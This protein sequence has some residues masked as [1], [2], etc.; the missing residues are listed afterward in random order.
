MQHLL[1]AMALFGGIASDTV[2][3]QEVKKDVQ[4]YKRLQERGYIQNKEEFAKHASEI[5]SKN[6]SEEEIEELAKVDPTLWA[7]VSGFLTFVNIVLFIAACLLVL[8]VAWLIGGYLID[9]FTEIPLAAYE[10]FGYLIAVTGVLTAVNWPAYQIHIAFPCSL[11]L[12]PTVA[13]THKRLDLKGFNCFEFLICSFAWGFAA[14]YVNSAVLGFLSV[15]AFFGFLGFS[16]FVMPFC[17]IIGFNDDASIARGTTSAFFI[18]L[19]HQFVTIGNHDGEV[20][21]LFADGMSI[22]GPF[23]Y[24]I[25]L[26]IVANKW[27]CRDGFQCLVLNIVTIISGLVA[28]YVGATYGD[29]RLLG[30]SGTLFAIWLIEKY[31]EIPW[32]GMGWAWSVLGLSG[33]LYGIAI[34]SQNHPEYFMW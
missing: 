29:S 4:A 11:A 22:M 12:I 18:T 3:I 2:N 33:I 19:I 9:F 31:Y 14:I 26:L 25:G 21:K 5:I 30:I 10:F 17:A 23:V 24:F 28:M 34:Y 16:V 1:L 13:L 6:L 7:K 8:A 15:A 20:Y 27:Y 32:K